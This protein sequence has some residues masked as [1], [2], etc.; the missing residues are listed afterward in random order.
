M[1]MRTLSLVCVLTAV[2]VLMSFGRTVKADCPQCV[3]GKCPLVRA[4]A[5]VPPVC[6]ECGPACACGDCRCHS[7]APAVALARFQH[8]AKGDRSRPF[9][10][11]LFHRRCR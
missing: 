9:R 7:M 5:G 11:R 3:N 1:R 10:H 2:A 6:V 4:Q 8:G